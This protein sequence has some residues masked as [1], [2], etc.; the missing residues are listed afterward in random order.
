LGRDPGIAGAVAL[1]F[2]AIGIWGVG[3]IYVGEV[4]RGL[5]LFLSGVALRYI[6]YFTE[7]NQTTFAFGASFAISIA[8]L[9][10]QTYDAYR[11][12]C[13]FTFCEEGWIR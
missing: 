3:H 6:L 12:A 4:T 1:V 13:D 7:I 10:W 8:G 9:L 11:I 2:G 5:V